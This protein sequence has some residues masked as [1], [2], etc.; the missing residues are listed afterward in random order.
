MVDDSFEPGS[1]VDVNEDSGIVEVRWSG[2]IEFH[3]NYY[4]EPQSMSSLINDTVDEFRERLQ[5]AIKEHFA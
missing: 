5:A 2:G 3:R 1:L 4:F